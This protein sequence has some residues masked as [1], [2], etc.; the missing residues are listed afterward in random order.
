[1]LVLQLGPKITKLKVQIYI[2]G[3]N[4]EYKIFTWEYGQIKFPSKTITYSQNQNP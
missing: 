4:N 2:V 3:L 1:M